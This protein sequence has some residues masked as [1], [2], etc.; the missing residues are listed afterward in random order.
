MIRGIS[1][2]AD[3]NKTALE[4]STAG[5][6]RRL[7]AGNAA[8]FFKLQIHNRYVKDFIEKRRGEAAGH[9]PKDN[10]LE[11]SGE[12]LNFEELVSQI[13]ANLRQLSP[14]LKYL[15]PSHYIPTPR[16]IRSEPII[17]PRSV[18]KR[19]IPID[20]RD[21]L[22]TKRR[23]YINVPPTFPDNS[24]P[25]VI[26]RD[27]LT[28][29]L[30]GKQ[31]VPIVVDGNVVGPPKRT[32]E[33]SAQHQFF[34]FNRDN[35]QYVFI[36]NSLPLNSRT[37]TDFLL[38]QISLHSDDYFIFVVRQGKELKA[39][40]DFISAS[41]AD[42]WDLANIPFLEIAA[43]I[44]ANFQMAAPEAEVAALK[45]SQTFKRFGLFAHPSYFAGIPPNSLVAL[46]QANRR[47][48]LIQL[49]TDGFLTFLVAQDRATI[50]LSRTTRANFLQ[51]LAVDL[52]V[53]KRA[54]TPVTLAAAV[55]EFAEEFDFEIDPL[56]WTSAFFE[57]G[58]L[59][60]VDGAVRFGL[61]FV[62]HYLLA[63][64]L[65]N[66]PALAQKYFQYEIDSVDMATF[67]LYCELGPSAKLI[68]S[69]ISPLVKFLDDCDNRRREGDEDRSSILL[70]ND[71]KPKSAN[72]P[73]HVEVIRRRLT[74]L[75]KE[76]REGT[77]NVSEKQKMLDFIE[78]IRLE[79]GNRVQDRCPRRRR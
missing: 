6:V 21:A 3:D 9:E 61:P 35:Y 22:K 7:A 26:A 28:L 58:I 62:E 36:I 12:P 57:K 59:I 46:L 70:S 78:E 40:N 11:I 79:S 24:V 39:R 38:K 41:G 29:E 50:Q 60:N 65:S 34:E 77:G 66:D 19:D 55:A 67:D 53:E 5:S 76:V 18:E 43:F 8:S 73:V 56:V 23:L 74:T 2:Y 52:N 33:L 20:V 54:F 45:L 68:D 37:K 13:D 44:K 4:L 27:L 16:I 14:A 71:I 48:E 25:W 75:V 17:E 32:I 1:D 10:Q 51:Q 47:V 72:H 15:S 69:I 63:R 64:A 42:N 49:A 30:E 31:V